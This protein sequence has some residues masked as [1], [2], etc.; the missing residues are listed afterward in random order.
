MKR[1]VIIQF[2]S[3]RDGST[4]S[5]LML[6]D[7]LKKVGW[8]TFVTFA[9]D[10]PMLDTYREQ[11]HQVEVVSHKSWLRSRRLYRFSKNL[12]A[13]NAS[14]KSFH[15]YLSRVNPDL[16]YINTAVSYAGA[17][18]AR[19]LG[20]KI[21]WHVRELSDAVGGEMRFPELLR[22]RIQRVFNNWPVQTVVNSK[23]VANDMLGLNAG[24]F[25]VVPNAVSNAFFENAA[26]SEEARIAFDL[27][28]NKLV[29]GVP[30]TLR[31]MKG[32]PFFFEAFA[33]L[34]DKHPDVLA[35][36][37]GGGETTYSKTLKK[38]IR[39]LQ[40][41]N[42]V[43]FAGFVENMPLFYRACT[44]VCIPS[45]AEP[46]GRTVI[47]AFASGTPVVAS[48]VGGI[49]ETVKDRE[50]GLLVRYGDSEAL[51]VSLLEVMKNQSLHNQL[52]QKALKDA[53]EKYRATCYTERLL[54]IV[55]SVFQKN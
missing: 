40:I 8:E 53:K 18:A 2:S 27:P 39:A 16:V 55:E 52:Q 3:N 54:R 23:A 6:A 51:V 20:L 26:S 10:G 29:I 42:K 15:A 22:N 36:V 49:L 9:H 33:K 48:A 41:E 14:S 35:V 24:R 44:L 13:E 30:G 47:E 7:G 32:H 50:N 25:H 5:G 34:I 17:R 21:I 38:Q 43:R 4:F 1:I 28:E 37:T 45:V 19:K 46:F 11:G 12:I 31:P